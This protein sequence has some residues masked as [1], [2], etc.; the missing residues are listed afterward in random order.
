MDA[1]ARA[2]VFAR[3]KGCRPAPPLRERGA[4]RASC[5]NESSLTR[6]VTPHGYDRQTN[7]APIT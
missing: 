6:S 4:Q 3:L 5:I 1:N 2:C 7:D